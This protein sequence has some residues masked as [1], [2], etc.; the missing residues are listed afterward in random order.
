MMRKIY[1]LLALIIYSFS[2]SAQNCISLGCADAYTVTTDGTQ[3]DEASGAEW[4]CYNSYPRKQT[5]WQYFYSPSGSN[6]TQSF[7]SAADLDWLVFD[8]GTSLP[9][10]TCPVSP[11]GWTQVGC[12]LS[13]DPGGPTGPGFGS[14]PKRAT[15]RHRPVVG[16]I[17]NRQFCEASV[18]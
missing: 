3:A 7:S 4:G 14:G 15:R 17:R 6:Y 10:F 1:F 13:Y 16:S 2:L 12:D 5:F 11:S 8:M 18:I 9:T